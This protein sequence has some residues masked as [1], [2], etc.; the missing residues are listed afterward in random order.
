[1]AEAAAMT[2]FAPLL[3]LRG[4]EK[5]F[6]QPV[7]SAVLHPVGVA[8]LLVVQWWSLGRSLAGGKAT[9]RGR[10]YTAQS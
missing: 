4:I 9:W 1:M 2:A 7:L 5:R 6:V 10:A 8:G 3:S